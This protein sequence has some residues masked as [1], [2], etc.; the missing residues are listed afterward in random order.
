MTINRYK[1]KYPSLVII[2]IQNLLFLTQW[3]VQITKNLTLTFRPYKLLLI[4]LTPKK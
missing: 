2:N 4:M 1:F 3:H